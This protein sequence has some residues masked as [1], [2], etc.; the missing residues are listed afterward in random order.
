MRESVLT[1]SCTST[2]MPFFLMKERTLGSK[3]SV[4]A[5]VPRTNTSTHKHTEFRRR[6]CRERLGSFGHGS[7]SG[8][9]ARL[10]QV[11]QSQTLY[12]YIFMTSH[13]P[14]EHTHIRTSPTFPIKTHTTAQ[15]LLTFHCR[16]A[17]GTTAHGPITLFPS[18]LKP[19][20]LQLQM[21]GPPPGSFCITVTV[22]RWYISS[23]V[24]PSL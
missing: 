20:E 12:R 18:M 8:T 3:R 17:G 21:I 4:R 1:V 10:Q 19:R 15:L 13:L 5:P 16:I 9:Y 6:T 22:V 7:G 2:A 24:G 23:S 11:E 14:E